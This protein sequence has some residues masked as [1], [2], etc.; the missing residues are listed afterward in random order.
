MRDRHVSGFVAI[1]M[2]GLSARPGKSPA[3]LA[4]AADHPITMRRSIP[5]RVGCLNQHE[6]PN[7]G[8]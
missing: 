7:S 8:K 2:A 6:G 3:L 1:W 4:M 5:E